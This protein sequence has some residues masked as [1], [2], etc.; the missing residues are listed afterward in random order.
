MTNALSTLVEL[1][2]LTEEDVEQWTQERAETEKELEAE[3]EARVQTERGLV[4]A[5]A[6]AVPAE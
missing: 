5:E 3:L 4:L 2:Y 6:S 1:G